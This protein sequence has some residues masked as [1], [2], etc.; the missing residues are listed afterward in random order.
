MQCNC[1]A[2]L[3]EDARFCHKC[4]KPQFESDLARMREEAE[5][6]RPPESP[7]LAPPPVLSRFGRSK[8]TP[9]PL[10]HKKIDFANRRALMVSV[11]VALLT[12]FCF[13]ACSVLVPFAA[14]LLMLPLFCL[15]GFVAARLYIRQTGEIISTQSG[16]RLGF[17]T[18]L[19][20][21]LVVVVMCVLL[22]VL[23]SSPELRSEI[24]DKLTSQGN[25]ATE[26]ILKMLNDP[27]RF[28]LL[29]M[30]ELLVNF[31]LFTFPSML[32]GMLGVR[33]AA[34]K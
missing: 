24:I 32:G 9:P 13:T 8:A 2:Q 25:P 7:P 6:S 10:D 15:S 20:A 5:L 17:M 22:A 12:L 4:G 34:K 16:A 29:M 27:R 31:C 19:W 14:S 33:F 11:I 21:F 26:Q 30:G 23:I 3:P 28:I 18:A 1:G